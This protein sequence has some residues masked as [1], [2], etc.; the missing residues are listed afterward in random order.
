MFFDFYSQQRQQRPCRKKK[1]KNERNNEAN[2]SILAQW[3]ASHS[4]LDDR[5]VA[6]TCDAAAA[7]VCRRFLFF[8]SLRLLYGCMFLSLICLVVVITASQ[9][10][11]VF[12]LHLFLLFFSFF[13]HVVRYAFC[14]R[15][16]VFIECTIRFEIFVAYAL[17]EHFQL[18]SL[19]GAMFPN[20]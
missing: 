8:H 6:G 4:R 18:S 15:C 14:V 13:Q 2:Y 12:I 10:I 16:A 11:Q 20:A 7:T 17:A 9:H 3:S 5:I 19:A 1:K